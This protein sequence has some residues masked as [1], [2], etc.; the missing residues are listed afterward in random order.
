MILQAPLLDQFA[1]V[2]TSPTDPTSGDGRRKA[3]SRRSDDTWYIE[4]AKDSVK[5]VLPSSDLK[6]FYK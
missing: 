4:V 5:S 3:A 6:R 1:A 2:K